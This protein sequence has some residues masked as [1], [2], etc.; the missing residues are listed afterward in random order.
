MSQTSNRSPKSNGSQTSNRS[1][2]SKGVSPVPSDGSPARRR[3]CTAAGAEFFMEQSRKNKKE[4][5]KKASSLIKELETS[6]A[7]KDFPR[8]PDLLKSLSVAHE[9]YNRSRLRYKELH[10]DEKDIDPNELEESR[11]VLHS[12]QDIQERVTIA[13]EVQK[14]EEFDANGID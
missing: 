6:L 7:C 1:P 12:I 13:L 14:Y 4:A 3:K 8:M 5:E 9:E 11:Q 2:K 10:P